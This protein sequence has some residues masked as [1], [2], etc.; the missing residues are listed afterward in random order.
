LLDISPQINNRGEVVWQQYD[1]NDYEVFYWNGS[2]VTQITNNTGNDYAPR[3]NDN[4]QIVWYGSDGTYYEIFIAQNINDSDGDGIPDNIDNCPIKP[5][6]PQLGTCLNDLNKTC[7]SNADCSRCGSAGTCSKNQ[8][9]ADGDSKGDVCDNCP[10][11]CNPQQLDADG[12]G[13]GDLCDPTPGCGG[14]GSAA[15]ETPC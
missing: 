7:Q 12:D 4:G 8:E 1:G 13:L 6:G 11:V 5:N 10:T 9:N 3:I 15:C 14:C 2:V